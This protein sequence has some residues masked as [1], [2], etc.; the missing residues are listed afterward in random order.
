MRRPRSAVLLLLAAA[1]VLLGPWLA[2]GWNLEMSVPSPD[3]RYRLD[4]YHAR[5]WQRF[6]YRP[7][8]DEPGFA[9]VT[10]RGDTRALGTSDVIDLA[11]TPVFWSKDGVLVSTKAEFSFLARR[12]IAPGSRPPG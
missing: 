9:R 7:W 8:Y 10:K 5:R 12:W 4:F 11:D 2:G 3:G 1:A 6:A